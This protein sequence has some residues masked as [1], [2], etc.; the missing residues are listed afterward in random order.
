MKCFGS[1]N[2]FTGRCE[3]VSNNMKTCTN[4]CMS[5]PGVHGR[6][7]SQVDK[8]LVFKER[9]NDEGVLQDMTNIQSGMHIKATGGA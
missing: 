3:G 7:R 5:F 1:S 8:H 6:R 9:E 4:K 2:H